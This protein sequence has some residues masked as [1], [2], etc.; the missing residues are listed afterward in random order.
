[1]FVKGIKLDFPK[2]KSK[3]KIIFLSNN[4]VVVYGYLT[5]K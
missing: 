1:M 5:E 4:Q 2:N 3:N